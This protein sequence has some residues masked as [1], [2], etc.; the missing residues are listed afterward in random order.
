MYYFILIICLY[1]LFN[2]LFRTFRYLSNN[3]VVKE[4]ERSLV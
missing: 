1:I 3:L 4:V 2:K